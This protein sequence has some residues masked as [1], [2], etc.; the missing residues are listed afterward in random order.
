MS[1]EATRFNRSKRIK[2]TWNHIHRQTKLA[3]KYSGNSGNKL[4]VQP[5]R[6]N[7]RKSL[8]CGNP[9]CI[10]CCNPRKSFGHK[11]LKELSFF[12]SELI[13]DFIENDI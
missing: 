10:F 8:N 3:K 11:T 4:V 6:N 12:Q 7:K 13:E 1:D 2:K 5:H 9:R